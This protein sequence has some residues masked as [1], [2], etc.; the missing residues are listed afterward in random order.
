VN[1]EYTSC[2]RRC[3]SRHH[4]KSPLLLWVPKFALSSSRVVTQADVT[5]WTAHGGY[6]HLVLDG[7]TTSLL[8]A[9]SV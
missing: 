5:R 6:L 7:E 3:P 1:L 8:T 4:V 9:E 2:T